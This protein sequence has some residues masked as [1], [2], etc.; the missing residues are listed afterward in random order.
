MSTFSGVCLR[1]ISAVMRGPEGF[2]QSKRF[3]AGSLV[4]TVLAGGK[5]RGLAFVAAL[6]AAPVL[7]PSQAAAQFI[8]NSTAGT[9]QGA[10]T[11]GGGW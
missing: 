5:L 10:S 3:R 6:A 7:A 9:G 8:C 4:N 2:R 1:N 11:A